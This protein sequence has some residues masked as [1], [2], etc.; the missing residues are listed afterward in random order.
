MKKVLALLLV[1]VLCF[2][3]LAGCTS[4]QEPAGTDEPENTG[5]GTVYQLDMTTHDPNTSAVAVA[6]QAWVD[7]LRE[8][9]NGRLDITIHYNGALASMQD[10][11]AMTQSGG[12]DLMWGVCAA[13][14]RYFTLLEILNTPCI[15]LQN[16]L[17][18]TY[19]VQKMY[20]EMPL[21]KAEFDS[22]GL[23]LLAAHSNALSAFIST[24]QFEKVD[25]FKGEVLRANTDTYNA[26]CTALGSSTMACSGGEMYE[27][28]SK[29]VMSGTMIDV[30]VIAA[31]KSYE[32]APYLMDY[33][34]GTNS[35]F[36]AMNEDVYNSLPADLQE[37]LDSSFE[38]LSYAIATS[39]NDNVKELYGGVFDENM[40]VYPA[41]EELVNAFESITKDQIWSNWEKVV[42]ERG[43]DPEAMFAQI[44]DYLAEGAAKYGAE[45]NWVQ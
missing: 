43:G 15:G 1:L 11:A 2:G 20:N 6:L 37:K 24:K 19:V 22:M 31:T 14:S 39:C 29:N 28:F 34:F 21:I 27:N 41:S 17:Q 9:T 42:A 36:V 5:D 13:N 18:G 12:C 10:A 32:V 45:Y 8:E 4:S 26:L 3:A 7:Q 40:T 44:Q 38:S 23:H 35:G 33:N 30:T 25:D 16:S